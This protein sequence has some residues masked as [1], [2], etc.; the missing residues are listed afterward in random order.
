MNEQNDMKRRI[1]ALMAGL[2]LATM[3]AVPAFAQAVPVT[4]A[5]AGRIGTAEAVHPRETIQV[6]VI[7]E[8]TADGKLS[9][10]PVDGASYPSPSFPPWHYTCY[11][12]GIRIPCEFIIWL[13]D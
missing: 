4:D 2:A 12:E 10:T 5:E 7:E 6:Q 13:W 1:V 8:K 9:Y 3:M 11:F